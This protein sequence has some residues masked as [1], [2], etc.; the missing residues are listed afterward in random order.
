MGIGEFEIHPGFGRFEIHGFVTEAPDSWMNTYTGERESV[1]TVRTNDYKG[2]L[3]MR[4]DQ[5]EKSTVL[6]TC[7]AKNEL[8]ELIHEKIKEDTLVHFIGEIDRLDILEDFIEEKRPC[9]THLHCKEI[10]FYDTFD[11]PF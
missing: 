11:I 1:F 8:A 4:K 6:I 5:A 9:P 3:G 10:T 7:L 2:N